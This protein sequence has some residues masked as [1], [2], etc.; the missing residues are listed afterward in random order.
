MNKIYIVGSGPG[1]PELMTVKG[2]RLLQEADIVVHAGSLVNPVVLQYARPGAVLHD[3]ALMV[4]EE[5]VKVMFDGVEAGKKVVR[6]ASGDPSLF[7]TV[8]EMTGPLLKAGLEFEIVPGVSSSLAGAA[9][10][11]RELTVPEVAQT[12]ILT[13]CE[14]RTPMPALENLKDLASHQ[15][16]MVIFLSVQLAG[17]VEAELLAAYPPETP[18]AVVYKAS[19]PDEKVI[20]G[21]LENLQGLV[22]EH[23]ITKTALIYV[24]KF[25]TAEGTRSRLYDASFT[26]SFRKASSE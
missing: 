5:I 11:K 10:L 16:T 26:H 23:K 22:R 17:K 3:S 19:W 25:L 7:G 18:I 9:A 13:R 6:L 20:R 12:V 14:G 8:G 1:D 21:T 24:G 2:M 4:L 15:T